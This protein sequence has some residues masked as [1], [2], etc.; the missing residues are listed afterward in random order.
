MEANSY[1]T[2]KSMIDGMSSFYREHLP[3]QG[4][5]DYKGGHR[6]NQGGVTSEVGFWYLYGQG[7]LGPQGRELKGY[8]L[9]TN[10]L[11]LSLDIAGKITE[12]YVG[13]RQAE[14]GRGILNRANWICQARRYLRSGC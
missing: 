12:D 5:V 14:I 11:W 4:W 6:P 2:G 10:P 13:C 9:H 3:T 8:I 1:P 7:Q